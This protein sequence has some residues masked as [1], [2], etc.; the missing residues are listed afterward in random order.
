MKTTQT[1]CAFILIVILSACNTNVTEI[2]EI[3]VSASIEGIYLQATGSNELEVLVFDENVVEIR[4]SSGDFLENNLTLVFKGRWE[5]TEGVLYQ[6]EK[7]PFITFMLYQSGESELT[8][9]EVN[10]SNLA[11]VVFNRE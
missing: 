3:P 6:S 9:S 2:N 10:G 11:P 5:F 1:L 4:N 7:H 8:F